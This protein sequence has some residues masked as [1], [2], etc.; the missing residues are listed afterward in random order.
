MLEDFGDGLDG[1]WGAVDG[2]VPAG[3]DHFTADEG[4]DVYKRQ[5]LTDADEQRA[6]FVADRA[7]RH[8]MYGPDWEMDEAFLNAVAKLPPCAGIALGFDRLAMLATGALRICD[9]LWLPS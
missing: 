8:A 7:R 5:E 1:G 9:V 3:V 4:G 6:R 2:G